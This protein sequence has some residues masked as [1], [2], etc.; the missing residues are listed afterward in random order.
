[1]PKIIA[2]DYGL[3][4]CG[5]AVTDDSQIIASPL[6]TVSAN[7]LFPFLKNY[8]EKNTVEKI[9]L[10][11]PKRLNNTDTHLSQAVRELKIKL[12]KEFPVREI[13]LIDERFTSKMAGQSMV[14][15]GMNKKQRQNKE[16]V[17]Q[18]SATIILQSYLSRF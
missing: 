14:D 17:D 5:I 6:T 3:K 12:E 9:I 13:I 8:F 1:M 15:F 10:G 2:I 18:I 11:E 4:R 7:E 16:L